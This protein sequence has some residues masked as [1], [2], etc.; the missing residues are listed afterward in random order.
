MGG[1]FSDTFD[2]ISAFG[3]HAVDIQKQWNDAHKEEM[4][5]F[6]KVLQ[7]LP[8]PL[9]STLAAL[10]PRRQVLDTISLDH[11]V[12]VALTRESTAQVAL[13]PLNLSYDRLFRRTAETDSRVK[14]TIEQVPVVRNKTP[15]KGGG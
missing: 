7:P 13:K 2:L 4:E 11:R 14:I 15:N 5:K 9:G 10:H 8:P 3:H 6:K 12:R 1:S